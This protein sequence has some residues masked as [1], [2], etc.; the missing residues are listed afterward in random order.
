MRGAREMARTLGIMIIF[1][2]LVWVVPA[3]IA[4]KIMDLAFLGGAQ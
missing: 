2:S 3:L 1:M 4:M